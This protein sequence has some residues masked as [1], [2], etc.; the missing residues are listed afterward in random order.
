MFFPMHMHFMLLCLYRYDQSIE[1]IL[2]D[3]VLQKSVMNTKVSYNEIKQRALELI[4]P[5]WPKFH[6][7]HGWIANFLHRHGINLK[8]KY[9]QIDLYNYLPVKS[10]LLRVC[11]WVVQLKKTCLCISSWV[12]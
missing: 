11:M 5:H 2:R 4:S 9:L 3:W 1:T 6:A 7:S 12:L 10:Y 8:S